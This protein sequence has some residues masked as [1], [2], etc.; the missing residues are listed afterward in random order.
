MAVLLLLAITAVSSPYGVVSGQAAVVADEKDDGDDEYN[1]HAPTIPTQPED[2]IPSADDDA[3]SEEEEQQ[4]QP[5]TQERFQEQQ[6]PPPPREESREDEPQNQNDPVEDEE[7]AETIEP[8]DTED[9]NVSTEE[10]I[11]DP[12]PDDETA[13]HRPPPLDDRVRDTV[14]QST[15]SE[16]KDEGNHDQEPVIID[17][18]AIEPE[19][20]PTVPME[21]HLQDAAEYF[22]EAIRAREKRE[23]SGVPED[24]EMA[25]E[26]R[27]ENTT[28]D[29][30]AESS[31]KEEQEA[32]EE[33]FVED[34]DLVYGE[35]DEFD[36]R[37]LLDIFAAAA[38]DWLTHRAVRYNLARFGSN[39]SPFSHILFVYS[40]RFLTRTWIANGIGDHSNVKLLANALFNSVEETITWDVP[41]ESEWSSWKSANHRPSY[42]TNPFRNAYYRWFDKRVIF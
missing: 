32:S 35:D 15:S 24:D 33:R 21:E 28:E 11:P 30:T 20:P 22:K 6:Q 34:M 19:R 1:S 37:T 29:E 38:K 10:T 41:V 3:V 4:Q 25:N 17:A 5:T 40:E 42:S 12:A 14:M 16:Q 27:S 9:N 2:R 31:R 13:T 36:D 18:P 8:I 26:T 7:K 39:G 23:A